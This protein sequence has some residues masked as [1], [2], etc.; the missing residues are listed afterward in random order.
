MG[1]NVCRLVGKPP[2]TRPANY[3]RPHRQCAPRGLSIKRSP[4]SHSPA[5]QVQFRSSLSASSQA[6]PSVKRARRSIK[7]ARPK[8]TWPTE[9]SSTLAPGLRFYGSA[10]RQASWSRKARVSRLLQGPS[11]SSARIYSARASPRAWPNVGPATSLYTHLDQAQSGF[12]SRGG[13]GAGRG[14]LEARASEQMPSV[15]GANRGQEIR[16]I[17]STE[18]RARR[19]Q[20]ASECWQAIC[21]RPPLQDVANK[22]ARRRQEVRARAAAEATQS[23][24][25]SIAPSRYYRGGSGA[26]ASSPPP[27]RP[28]FI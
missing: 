12:A 13:G 8:S 25:R 6:D 23:I 20:L 2:S 10:G 21:A 14:A 9:F 11:T 27:R 4:W 26:A 1:K 24:D 3:W 5:G 7:F 17:S 28:L 19:H 15:A 22:R 16:S 18:G